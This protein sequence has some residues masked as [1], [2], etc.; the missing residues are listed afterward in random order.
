MPDFQ[1]ITLDPGHFHAAL[2]QKEM[3]PEVSNRVAVFAPV[4]ADLIQHLNRVVGFNSRAQ[5]PTTWELD[6]HASPDFLARMLAERPG[7]IVV[8]S[9]RNRGKID[10]I[11]AS[12]DAG[13]NVLSDKPWIIRTED[14]GALQEALAAAQAKR[15]L[16]YDIMTERFEITSILQ[17]ELVNDADVFGE[18]VRGTEQE[19]GVYMESVHQLLKLV[20]GVPNLRPAWFFDVEQ[21]GEALA[22]V[23]THLVDLAQWTLF[24]DAAIDYR[25][26][27]DMVA[28][29]RWPTKMTAEQFQQVTGQAGPAMDYY[30]NTCVSYKLRGVH[31]KLDV[32]WNWQAPAGGG[33]THLA[34][35]RGT[36]SQV[37]VRQ[38]KEENWRPELY[39]VGG[40]SSVVKNK[41]A[42]LAKTYPGIGTEERKGDV[43]VTI[44]DSYR[45]GHEAHFAQVTNQFFGYLKHPE[46]VPAWENP[47]MLAKYWVTTQ[48]TALSHAGR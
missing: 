15:V 46:T 22:D 35:Y 37:E 44:P 41:V 30:C 13:L 39:V 17:R 34:V 33:D 42:A 47:N 45:V 12:V 1:L 40:D 5:K 32:L 25:K 8:L 9:G 19:P 3:Y 27:I 26:D 36:K 11:R 18:M 23:G 14:F 48:G 7:N 16:A 6:V 24:P 10:Y 20:A 43:L 2:I 31:I 29:S 21:Q 4:G 38:G 28:A